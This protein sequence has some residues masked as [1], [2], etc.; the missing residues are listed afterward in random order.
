MS[1]ITAAVA[2][3]LK[4]DSVLAG[5]LS[6]YNGSP[7]VFTIEPVPGD[8]KLPYISTPPNIAD[9]DADTKTTFGRDIRRDIRCFAPADGSATLVEQIAER[10]RWLFHRQKFFVSGY[11]LVQSTCAGPFLLPTDGTVYG[12]GLTVRLILQEVS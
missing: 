9:V 7:A 2:D 5:L 3:R 6:T 4:G 10:V 11:G 12:L 1:A 8:A